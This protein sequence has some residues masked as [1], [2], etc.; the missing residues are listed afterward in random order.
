MALP[1]VVDGQVR[2]LWVVWGVYDEEI[3]MWIYGSGDFC[4]AMVYFCPVSSRIIHEEQ[5][6]QVLQ[7][8]ETLY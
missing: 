7:K 8:W 1:T 5:I 6:I 3:G 4:G 2:K